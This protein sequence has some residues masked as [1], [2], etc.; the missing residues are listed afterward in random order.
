MTGKAGEFVQQMLP[1]YITDEALGGVGIYREVTRQAWSASDQVKTETRFYRA[2]RE[3]DVTAFGDAYNQTMVLSPG[4]DARVTG[5]KSDIDLFALLLI[6]Q[7]ILEQL[8][9]E[10]E[11]DARARKEIRTQDKIISERNTALLAM[12]DKLGKKRRANLQES[13]P[14]VAALCEELEEDREHERRMDAM[15]YDY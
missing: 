14:K 15:E 11:A 12:W 2:H 6:H 10:K 13:D 3:V 7:G 8:E 9:Y 5:S 1:M 4:L